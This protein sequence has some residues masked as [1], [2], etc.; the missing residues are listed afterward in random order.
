[1]NSAA[2]SAELDTATLAARTML[3]KAATITVSLTTSGSSKLVSV[4]VYNDTGHKLPTGYPEGRRMWLNLKAFDANGTLLYESGA[5]NATTGELIADPDIKVYETK[6]G[7]TPELAAVAKKPAGESF[8]FVLNN[9][10]IKDNRIPPRGYTQAAFNVDG[11]R[12]VGATFADGQYWDDTSY[13]VPAQAERVSAVLY[14]QTSSKEYIDFL[15]TNGG[16][17]G[18]TLGQLWD[19]S[20]SPPE[21]M[22][23]GLVNPLNAYFPVIF[24]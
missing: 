16:L 22:A 14:Y 1:L 11:L 8:H 9:T 10:V 23:V 19:S 18:L 15:R 12:P 7:I 24:K 3:Q 2:D 20:K 17:D 5:Y 4:R 6:Q 21:V 13:V